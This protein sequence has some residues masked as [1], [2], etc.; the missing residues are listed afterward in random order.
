MFNFGQH[1]KSLRQA[2]NLTQ[3]QLAEQ[4]GASESIIQRYEL[5]SRKPAY[6]T[7][8][9]LADYFGVT[10]DYLVGRSDK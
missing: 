4:I 6:D 2:K 9:A 7:L 1:L 10:L 8:I 5:G 3:K